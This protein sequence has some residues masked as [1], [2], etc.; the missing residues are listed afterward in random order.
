MRLAF[1]AC[2]YLFA[3]SQALDRMTEIVQKGLVFGVVNSAEHTIDLCHKMVSH[4]YDDVIKPLT[5][6]SMSLARA[7]AT[8]PFKVIKDPEAVGARMQAMS[9]ALEEFVTKEPEQA[10]AYVVECLI[11]LPSLVPKLA[12]VRKVFGLKKACKIEQSLEK[13]LAKTKKVASPVCAPVQEFLKRTQEL[14]KLQVKRGNAFFDKA[15]DKVKQAFR[16]ERQVAVATEAGIVNFC[17]KELVDH[18]KR[19]AKEELKHAPKAAVGGASAGAKIEGAAVTETVG[20]AENACSVGN[21]LSKK[22][23]KHFSKHIPDKF[24]QEVKCMPQKNLEIVLG[25]RTFFNPKWSEAEIIQAVEE[26]FSFFKSKGLT[27]EL[28]YMFKNEI[29]KVFIHPNGKLGT[30][31]GMHK[32]PVDYFIK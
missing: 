29:I 27:G 10:V 21:I 25:K 9:L 6:A 24:A 31:W 16:L 17:E 30:S 7:V 28:D 1:I 26:G 32:L 3:A 19:A 4:P 22:D 12:S 14:I 18:A 23:I 8:F 5:L 2:H 11:P 15:I 20:I 13:I